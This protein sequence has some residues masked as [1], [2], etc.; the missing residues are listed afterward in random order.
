MKKGTQTK[1]KTD[2]VRIAKAIINS[3]NFG[4]QHIKHGKF[5]IMQSNPTGKVDIKLRGLTNAISDVEYYTS[6]IN[7][8]IQPKV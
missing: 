2:K 8:L 6:K 1:N 7:E 4:L 5:E 3:I